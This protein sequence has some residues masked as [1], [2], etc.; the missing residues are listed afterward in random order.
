MVRHGSDDLE[1]RSEERNDERARGTD[2]GPRSE[3]SGERS[4]SVSR[5]LVLGSAAG[6][7]AVLAGGSLAAAQSGRGPDGDGP[8]GRTR[9]SVDLS[10]LGRYSSG[11]YDEGAAEIVGHDPETQRLFV[12]NANAGAV[13]VLD[14]ADPADPTKVATIDTA[15]AFADAG[16]TN[17]LDVNG[18][19]VAVA[20]ANEDE[21]A[22]GRVAVY[23]TG[24]LDLLGTATVG[25]LPDLVTF[26]PDGRYI[27]TADEGEP[28][29]YEGGDTNPEGSISVVDVSAGVA[30]ATVRTAGFTRFNDQREA[31]IDAGV[32]IFGPDATVAEDLEP[33][34]IT[35]DADSETAWVTLQEN[36]ALAVVDIGTAT[37]T[38]IVPL[39]YKDYSE[40]GNGLDAVDDGEI[41]ITTQ[42]LFGMYQPD[43]ITSFQVRGETFLVT[44]NEGDTREAEDFPGFEEVTTVGEL[45]AD[46]KLA[47]PGEIPTELD[48]VEVTA[49]PPFVDGKPDSYE[50]LYTFGGRSFAIWNAAGDLVFESGDT[51]EQVTAE[52]FPDNFNAD[53]NENGRDAES[54]ASGPEPEGVAVGK[55]AGEQY[56]FIGLEEIGGIMVFKVTDPQRREPTF[57][58]YI[59]SRDFSVDPETA[60]EENGAPADAAGDLAPEGVAFVSEEDSPV[61][62]ALLAVGFE[63]SGTTTLY[64]IRPENPGQ[65]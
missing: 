65:G 2:G 45:R 41:D 48:A 5:R 58:Q 14:I 18:G 39:G 20:L 15:D 21:Q 25:P 11:V 56:A 64:R 6:L 42:P 50:D 40:A 34:Y 19:R 46:D 63:V 60:I 4:E 10:V 43:S 24:S 47:E 51:F 23:E 44:A 17:S 12:V 57:V 13:D 16:D 3:S 62:D 37:V 31:L 32:R 36:N 49:N 53:D 61:D 7:G 29:G 27:L 33:E 26:T 35:V 9:K 22:R 55:V 54:P 8:P 1:A 38:D 52:A 30:S 28:S 59:N